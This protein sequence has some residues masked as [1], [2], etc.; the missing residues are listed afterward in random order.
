M[1]PFTVYASFETAAAQPL[2]F[3]RHFGTLEVANSDVRRDEDRRLAPETA[4][5][6]NLDKGQRGHIARGLPAAVQPAMGWA[7]ALEKH[8]GHGINLPPSYP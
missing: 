1:V 3:S 5:V 8:G 4:D 6:S 7:A 2:A